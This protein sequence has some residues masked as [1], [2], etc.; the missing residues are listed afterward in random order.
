MSPCPY[1]GTT[2]TLVLETGV[3]T[4]S[5]STGPTFIFI[6]SV[7]CD[8]TYPS[9]SK[10]KKEVNEFIKRKAGKSSMVPVGYKRKR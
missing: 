3:I 7:S 9:P 4:S 10:P 1:T 5:C 8:S 2:D 6:D